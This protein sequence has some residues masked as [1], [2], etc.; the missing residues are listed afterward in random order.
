MFFNQEKQEEINK[1]KRILKETEEEIA[2]LK[3]DAFKA[4]DKEKD[5][6]ISIEKLEKTIIKDINDEQLKL[7]TLVPGLVPK[8]VNSSKYDFQK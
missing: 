1:Y 2:R 5:F 8:F 4:N 7:S 6:I 3:V